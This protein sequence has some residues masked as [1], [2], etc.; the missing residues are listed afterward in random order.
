MTRK[1]V[2][3]AHDVEGFSPAGAEDTFLSRLLIDKEGVGAGSFVIN[4]FTLKP[5]KATELGSHPVPYEEA[6]YVL[7]GTG[8]VQL[9]EPPEEY[10]V[11][12]NSV[13]F[14]PGGT[15]HSVENLGTDDMEILTVMTAPLKEGS[16][17]VYD[18]R[19]KEWGTTFKFKP[20]A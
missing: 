3:E 18:A 13:V 4:H 16:N 10:A 17:S 12:P 2:F 5:G 15:Q 1:L 7:R 11:G 20:T 6:Y 8:R 14:I 9:G 19:L